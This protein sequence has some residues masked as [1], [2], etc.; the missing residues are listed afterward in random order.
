MSLYLGVDAGG[1]KTHAVICDEQG[2]I[3]GK[4]A[5]GNGNHQ[6]HREHAARNIEEAC[7]RAL[8]EAGAAKEDISYAYFGLA[9]ADREADYEILRPMIGALG[10]PKHAIACDT[11]IGMRAGTSRPYGAALICGTGFNSAARNRAGEELQYGGFGFLYGDGYAGGSGFATLAFRAVIRAWDERGPATLLTS[12]VLEQ[13]GYTSVEPMYEDVL[14]GRTKIPPSLVKTLFLAAEAGDEVATWILENEGEELAN[15]VCT[16]IR[17]LDMADEAF[18]IVYIGSVL[19]RPN[20][21]ILTDAIERIVAV[22]APHASCVRL[23]S[24]PVSGALLC[25]MDA[26]GHAVDVETEAKLKAFTFEQ[27]TTV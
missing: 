12:L 14:Y 20:S 24:D 15:A 1:S 25:A 3:L 6:I 22:R 10:Y 13:M 27:A 23:T 18:D 21:S 26:D 7:N 8:Q 19:N 2:N 16:L 5:S 11:I 17:R 4:G 9:G